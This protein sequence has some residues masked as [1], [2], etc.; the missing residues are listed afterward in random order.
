[1]MESILNAKIHRTPG[2][3]E[4]SYNRIVATF[5][6]QYTWIGD[7]KLR[8]FVSHRQSKLE[9]KVSPNSW[10]SKL[11]NINQDKKL[12]LINLPKNIT[13]SR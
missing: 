13:N 12:V 10:I 9:S 7:R 2:Y 8:N 4:V 5:K 1:M 6:D 11:Q 3:D